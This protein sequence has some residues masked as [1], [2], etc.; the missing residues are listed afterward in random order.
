MQRV[1]KTIAG[2]SEEIKQLKQ[3]RDYDELVG[4]ETLHPLVNVVDF[5]K[6]PPLHNLSGR[7]M[8]G[9]YAIYLKGDKYSELDYGRGQYHYEEGALVFF[10][11]G[12]VIGTKDDGEVHQLH[13]RVLMFHPDLLQGTS[14]SKSLSRYSYFSYNTNEALFPTEE[15]RAFIISMFDRIESELRH[16]DAHSLPIVVDYIRLILD[17]CVRFY[18]R[19]FAAEHVQN[20]DILARF[21]Q[22]LDDYFRSDMP[23]RE[24]VP[25]VSY[26]AKELCLST[27]YFNDLIR[28]ATGLSAL[29]LMHRKMLDIAK[30]KLAEP[31]KRM[32][33]IADELGFQQPQN[34]SNWFKK[35]EGCTPLQY[36]K[37]LQA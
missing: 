18:D 5:A 34:F 27:N 9:Y 10:A 29:K 8:F 12:Q 25:T 1:A 22:L 36:R 26:C 23:L 13:T 11:P 37:A 30:T 3:I 24:G 2:M 19:Q 20:L 4:A 28:Q 35:Q 15:E 14:L 16:P 7:R 21:E 31:D 17:S 32:V 6:L 33:E